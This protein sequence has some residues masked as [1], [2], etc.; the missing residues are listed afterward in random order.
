MPVSPKG[1]TFCKLIH[2]Q[3]YLIIV[4]IVPFTLFYNNTDTESIDF[5]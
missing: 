3:I 5:V 4:G 1:Q 2:N